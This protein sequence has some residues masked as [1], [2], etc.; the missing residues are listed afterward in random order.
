MLYV[1]K[2]VG[3]SGGSGCNQASNFK[4]GHNFSL[5]L[6]M[7]KSRPPGPGCSKP[8]KAKPGKARILI[9]DL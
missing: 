5:N 2:I 6:A 4:I 3:P 8:D 7:P 1:I 9:S